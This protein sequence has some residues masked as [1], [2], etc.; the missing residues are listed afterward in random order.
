M[1]RKLDRF[2]QWAGERMG[3]EI[4]TSVSDDFKALE[5]DMNVRSDGIII[6]ALCLVPWIAANWLFVCYTKGTERVHRSTTNYIKSISKKTE[7]E[8]K[9][10]ALPIGYLGSNLINHGEGLD[11]QTSYAQCLI[12]K[13][14]HIFAKQTITLTIY[15]VFGRAE[16]RLSRIQESYASEA[17]STWL[18]SLERSLAQLREYQV[19][20]YFRIWLHSFME[21]TL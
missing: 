16:E 1:N 19:G 4:K 13:V 7:G 15:L 21:L 2:K 6:H 14:D 5:S 12:S 10:K 18:E 9:D 17:S 20:N 11:T 3:G 8:D